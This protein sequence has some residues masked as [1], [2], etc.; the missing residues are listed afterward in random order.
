MNDVYLDALQPYVCCHPKSSN[1]EFV[2]RM[3]YNNNVDE[4]LSVLTSVLYQGRKRYLE[5]LSTFPFSSCFFLF[6]VLF[7]KGL[8]HSPCLLDH[9]V[10]SCSSMFEVDSKYLIEIRI[11]FRI[12]RYKGHFYLKGDG[13]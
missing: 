10:I 1:S 13:W 11:F 2:R 4:Y 9:V 3:F 7:E 8:Y 5:Y 12:S 6:K